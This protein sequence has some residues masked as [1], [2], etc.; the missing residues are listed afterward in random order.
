MIMASK[1]YH[2]RI[3]AYVLISCLNMNF[4]AAEAIGWRH[5]PPEVKEMVMKPM[6]E[7]IDQQAIDASEFYET[8][9]LV[10]ERSQMASLYR[11]ALV[12]KEH[13]SFSLCRNTSSI[14]HCAHAGQYGLYHGR[15]WYDNT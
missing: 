10:G 14:Y 5:L 9:F 6:V 15:Y 11:L 8:G 2:I 1:M 7:P 13:R 12:N 4:F 3:V